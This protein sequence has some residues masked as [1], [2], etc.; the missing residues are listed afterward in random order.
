MLMENIELYKKQAAKEASSYINDGMII[1]LGSGSTATYFLNELSKLIKKNNLKSIQGIP[2]SSETSEKA[3]MLGI[4][5]TSLADH[6]KIHMTVDGADEVDSDLNMI[7]GGGGALLREKI[8]VQASQKVVII[9]D[10]SKL[11]K[12]LGTNWPVPIE[13]LPFAWKSEY[14]FVKTLGA[15]V[16][17]RKIEDGKIYQTDQKNYILDAD[18]GII[19][20]PIQLCK[21]L[22]KRAAI[23]EH[24]LFIGLTSEVIVAGKTGIR[25]LVKV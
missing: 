14:Q 1:G 3:R 11:S 8:L 12:K 2:S 6:P 18:F 22:D 17:L 19:R 10:E 4:K 7:K 23:M 15:K 25:H 20:N 21:I 9:I 5:L 16:A 24:G 13:V